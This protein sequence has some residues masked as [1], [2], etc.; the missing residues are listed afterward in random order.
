MKCF[1]L[2]CP[3]EACVYPL[4]SFVSLAAPYLRAEVQVPLFICF[5]HASTDVS[6]FL[7]DD[8]WQWAY[9]CLTIKKTDRA[10]INRDSL[11][12]RYMPVPE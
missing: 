9:V 4:V 2:G 6:Q 5:D 12:V 3:N 10:D 7:A 1:R 11:Q 8:G